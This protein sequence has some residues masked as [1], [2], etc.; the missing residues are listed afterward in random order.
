MQIDCNVIVPHD[1]I[2]SVGHP[3]NNN[4][5]SLC[6]QESVDDALEPK[7]LRSMR[8][9]VFVFATRFVYCDAIRVPL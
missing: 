9:S 2:V 6:Y 3:L 7:P 8:C 5:S 4:W 1:H